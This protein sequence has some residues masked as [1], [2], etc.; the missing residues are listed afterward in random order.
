MSKETN[1]SGF[2]NSSI[3]H[4]PSPLPFLLVGELRSSKVMLDVQVLI[5]RDGK[6]YTI[7]GI[8]VK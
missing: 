1:C 8:E 5:L 6:T 3:T 2:F 7:Q 4:R